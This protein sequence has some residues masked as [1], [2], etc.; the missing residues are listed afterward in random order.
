MNVIVVLPDIVDE[1]L[2]F[3]FPGGL[4]D[5]LDAL[6]FQARIL[7]QI[8]AVRHIGLMMFVMMEFQCLARHVRFERIV[9]VGQCRKF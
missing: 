8:V 7:Q 6:P 1:A 2:V 4:A 5:L 9:R 3:L